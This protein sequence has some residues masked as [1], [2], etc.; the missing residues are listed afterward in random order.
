MIQDAR[1]AGL[2]WQLIG[3]LNKTRP[4][5]ASEQYLF[6]VLS[7]IYPDVTKIELRREL[8]YL[9]D[10]ELLTLTK[11]PIG[12]WF[13]DLTRHGVD[14]AEYTIECEAGIARPEKY[15]ET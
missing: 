11:Q 8:D 7:L 15:W 13:A 9:Q 2:R 14:I 5:T 4:H 12:L 6:D 1:T 10:R 3:I